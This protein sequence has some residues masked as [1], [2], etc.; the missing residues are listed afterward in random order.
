MGAASMALPACPQLY[1]RRAQV[2]CGTRK[3]GAQR[4]R[5]G[6]DIEKTGI[7]KPG[8]CRNIWTRR[9]RILKILIFN[10]C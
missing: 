1:V 8:A 9:H 7:W 2:F 10:T 5:G 4:A 3:G 6:S